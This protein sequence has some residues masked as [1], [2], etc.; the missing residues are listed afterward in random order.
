MKIKDK[1][2]TPATAT[3][4]ELQIAVHAIVASKTNPRRG[5][6]VVDDLLQTMPEQGQINAVTLRPLAAGDK[7]RAKGAEYELICGERRWI[8]AG[9]LGWS[10]LRARVQQ[11]DDDAAF[12]QQL[13]ENASRADIDPLDEAISLGKL[14]ERGYA[15]DR[16]VQRTGIPADRVRGRLSVAALGPEVIEYIRSGELPYIAGELLARVPASMQVAAARDLAKVIAGGLDVRVEDVTGPGTIK[17]AMSTDEIRAYLRGR[18]MMRLAVAPFEGVLGASVAAGKVDA[19]VIAL[20][21]A[22]V[23]DVH[24]VHDEL[25]ITMPANWPSAVGALKRE[26]RWA[27]L[28]AIALQRE[29]GHRQ[30]GELLASKG[31]GR[32]G[33]I[34]SLLGVD[35]RKIREA[36][37][38]GQ[39]AEAAAATAK[40][41]GGKGSKGGK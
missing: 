19:I 18:Y 31:G 1:D 15:V 39:K 24:D 38:A 32:A 20:L 33:G 8:A 12:E 10:T 26:Q 35:V 37:K 7:R 25:G 22:L 27:W 14:H 11:L 30:L 17:V 29:V 36:A 34:L 23:D 16:I 5:V 21:S 3:D 13:V 28:A 4:A 2:T 40:G 9:K 41:K 6:I